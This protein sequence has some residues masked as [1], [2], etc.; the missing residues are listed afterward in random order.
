MPDN[1]SHTGKQPEKQSSDDLEGPDFSGLPDAWTGDEDSDQAG[2]TDTL[3]P[4]KPVPPNETRKAEKDALKESPKTSA[5]E[6][7]ETVTKITS[8]KGE[9]GTHKDT[10]EN[11]D[12][13]SFLTD[14][15]TSLTLKPP[16][17]KKNNTILTPSNALIDMF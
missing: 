7:P 9:S 5:K 12:E 16:T 11:N 10:S 4:S 17:S 6:V 3:E 15:N 14:K 8:N 1:K 13:T 2:S